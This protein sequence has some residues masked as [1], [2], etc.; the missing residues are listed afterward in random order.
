MGSYMGSARLFSDLMT[1]SHHK[2]LPAA[3]ALLF[4]QSYNILLIGLRPFA[5]LA[6]FVGSAWPETRPEPRVSGRYM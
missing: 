4:L 1:P 6:R 2:I 5:A 3:H